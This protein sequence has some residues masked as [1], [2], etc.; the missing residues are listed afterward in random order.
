MLTMSRSRRKRTGKVANK[1]SGQSQLACSTNASSKR[2]TLLVSVALAII[3]AA[4]FGQVW[5]HEFIEYDDTG[6]VSEN[7]NVQ[8]GLTWNNVI[9]AFTT[10]SEANWHPLTWLSHM[11]DC[12]IFGLHSGAHHLVNVLLHA[13]N[14]ILLFLLL[15]RMT[16][17]L[18]GGAFVAAL[19]ALHPLHV[20]SVAW[21]AER[22]DVL[23][24]LFWML[25]MAAYLRY[26]QRP[27][28]GRYLAVFFLL[29]LGLMAKPMLVT[30][31]FVL[32]LLDYWP[33]ARF[34]KTSN[35]INKQ[36]TANQKTK[37][38]SPIISLTLEKLPLVVLVVA[39][40]I[41]TF[42]FQHSMKAVSSLD[43]VPLGARLANALV[44]YVSYIG[45]MFWP[46]KLAIFYPFPHSIPLWQILASGLLLAGIT[47]VV[48]VWIKRRPWL[49]VGWLWFL[50]T[51]VPVIG[52]VKVGSQAL[53][54]R[55]TYIPLIGLFIM[56][57]WGVG[58]SLGKRPR[59]RIAL[60]FTAVAVLVSLT[61]GA[62][63][64]IRLWRDS[65]TL[66]NHALA[67]TKR[68]HLAHNNL[69]GVFAK[70]GDIDQAM[71]HWRT[72]LSFKPNYG[73]AHYNLAL[74]LSQRQQSDDA[75]EHYRQAIKYQPDNADAYNNLGIELRDKGKTDEAIQCYRKAL[76]LNWDY[77]APHNNLGLV[78][79]H[80][81][82]TQEAI[83]HYR[84]ALRIRPD[85]PQAH[86]NLAKVFADTG[87]PDQA[88]AHY[89]RALDL[90]PNKAAL[91]NDYAWFL[92]TYPQE[93]FRNPP[94]A[95]ELARRA[96]ELTRYNKASHL[97]TLAA[98]YAAAGQFERAVANVQKAID[99][100]QAAGQIN[101]TQQLR[102]RKAL[103]LAEKPY[104]QQ[105]N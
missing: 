25:T 39:S 71:M 24:T 62:W 89:R 7:A 43:V 55:Y 84:E 21:A 17:A 40:C 14:T 32:L 76:E 60:K 3:V 42:L 13:I 105:P 35:T 29:A 53:A 101:L 99:L 5:R 79:A 49:A 83:K 8:R 78:L 34:K 48:F 12:E 10:N 67:V 63:Q 69:G 65:T 104:Y 95:I 90:L 103:Y 54:D 86:R 70:Q 57:T 27:R 91:L 74:A 15:R 16:G 19:F 73:S 75:I 100:A 31:P 20:Q 88:V 37:Q 18:W 93:Q 92:A 36:P 59:A 38:R 72:A 23:S 77:H 81:G 87:Q 50:G 46:S 66:F 98:A 4:V 85:Y 1:A 45:K 30:L 61:V 56:I 9:W 97:D 102:Q 47:V 6:Y 96:C 22:K 82:R 80:Q 52:L 41:I 28:I 44:S 58:A 2:T 26:V 33:L 68:N 51:L 94:Q 11:L 64:E